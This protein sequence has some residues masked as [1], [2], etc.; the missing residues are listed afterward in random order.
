MMAFNLAPLATRRDM[1]MLGVVHRAALRKG[2][3]HFWRF[4]QVAEDKTHTHWTRAAKRRHSRHLKEP[5]QGRFLE[6]LRRSALG[7][8]AVY[9]ALPN[10][11][12]KETT[13]K[14]FQAKLRKL[15]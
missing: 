4:F 7:L 12:V 9:N 10:D 8:V 13:V 11:T 6:V 3:V 15:V 14:D 5:R 1:A 2:P